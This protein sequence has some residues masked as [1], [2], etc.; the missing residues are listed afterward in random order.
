M[1][2]LLV[3]PLPRA[4][5]WQALTILTRQTRQTV[6]AINQSISGMGEIGNIGNLDLENYHIGFWNC[7]IDIDNYHIRFLKMLPFESGISI[8]KWYNLIQNGI[9]L[10]ILNQSVYFRCLCLVLLA[11]LCQCPTITALVWSSIWKCFFFFFSDFF[12]IPLLELS[13]SCDNL[14]SIL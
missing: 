9:F 3:M 12:E 8:W 6:R 1:C 14:V 13:L 10:S 11:D 2:L 4:F 5:C 7:N